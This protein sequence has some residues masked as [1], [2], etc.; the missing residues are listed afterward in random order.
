MKRLIKTLAVLAVLFLFGVAG[1]AGIFIYISSDLP[2]INTLED[3]NPPMNSKIVSRDGEVLLE[4]I[5]SQKNTD[6][7]YGRG[8]V[9]AM[10]KVYA[11][12]Y[13]LQFAKDDYLKEVK[14]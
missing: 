2:Q 6:T 1:V 7:E 4:I 14:L 9:E 10:Q 12:V 8:Y 13:A 3:Y 11:L 5:D